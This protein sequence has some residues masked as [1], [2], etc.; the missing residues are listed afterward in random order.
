MLNLNRWK[1]TT[2]LFLTFGMNLGA[3]AP[4]VTPLIAAAPAAAQSAGFRDVPDGYW[5]EDFIGALVNRGVIAGFPDGTFRPNAPVTRAQ[6]SAMLKGAFNK[7]K[8]RNTIN[9][10]DVPSTYWATPAI[11]N[12]YET[13]FLSGYPGSIFRPEQN[14]PREQVLVSLSNGLNYTST[15]PVNQVLDYYN[16]SSNISNFARPPIAAA[17][18][19]DMV[20]NYPIL[21]TLN[22]NRNATRAEVAA[23]IYQ[24]LVSQNAAPPIASAYVVSPTP[25]ATEFRIPAGSSIPVTYEYDKILLMQEETVPVTLTV[26]TNITTPD[27]QLLI[28]TGTK[29]AGDLKP[30]TGGTQF[31]AKELIFANGERQAFQATSQVITETETIRQGSAALNILKNAAIGSAAAAA[32]SGVTGDRTIAASEVLIGT[33]VGALT[34]LIQRFIGARSVDLIAVEPNTDLNL[35]LGN[36]LVVGIR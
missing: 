19:N 14:I 26:P 27:G 24:A 36:D 21:Q 15:Q 8:V 31:V 2:A 32:I 25:I 34:S 20:V 12:A 11:D 33:G 4:L 17:T 7:A 30:A 28:P 22:P 6:F 3:V 10:V 16:D 23:F 18:E 13:G 1:A 29:V 5:A 35:T 9:F